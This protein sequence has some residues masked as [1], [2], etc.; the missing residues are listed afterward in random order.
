MSFSVQVM[1]RQM[2]QDD[3][4]RGLAE[5]LQDTLALVNECSDLRRIKGATDVISEIS[6]A[7]LE[8]ASLIDEY[9]QLS[10]ASQFPFL[11]CWFAAEIFFAFQEELFAPLS[12]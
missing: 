4:I 10:L 9:A 7:V 12:Q 11:I 8:A 5:G 6:R 1:Q 2:Y 3:E